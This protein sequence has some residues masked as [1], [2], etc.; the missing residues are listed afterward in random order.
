MSEIKILPG[1]LSGIVSSIPSKSQAHRAL[2][3]AALSDQ[4]TFIKCEGES[5]DIS[6]TV[7][8]LNALGAKI[9]RK[10]GGFEVTP[11]FGSN[12]DIVMQC[13]ESGSTFRFLLPIAGALGITAAFMPKGRLPERPLSPMYEELAAHGCSLSPQGSV[14]FHTSG[15]LQPGKYSLDGG[16]SSQFVSGLLFALPLLDGSSELRLTGHLESFPYIELTLA[17]LRRFGIITEFDGS[18]FSIPGKQTYCSPGEV[19]VEGDWSNAAFWLGAG[20]IGG[21]ERISSAGKRKAEKHSNGKTQNLDESQASAAPHTVAVSCIGLNTSSAQG[22]RAIVEILKQFGA[23]VETGDTYVTVSGNTLRGTDIDAKDVPDLVPILAVVASSAHGTTVI[24]NAGRLRTKESDRL[25]SIT[26]V[27]LTLGADVK[28]TEDSLIIRG[29]SLL[30]GGSVSSHG[31]H[32]IAMAAAIAAT[33]CTDAVTISGADAANKS[34][35]GF[36]NDFRSLGGRTD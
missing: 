4:K 23:K 5:E 16:I 10:M 21:V 2:I 14:P 3:C 30:T 28:E 8:C 17:M 20:A 9:A 33:I 11:L 31:D 34:Y 7:E 12:R 27:M 29:G 18:V 6:A 36:F 25:A 35:P 26:E 13:R 32:R 15:R 19:D 1:R 24:R 22:D